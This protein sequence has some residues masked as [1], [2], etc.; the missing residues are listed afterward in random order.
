[1]KREVS[2]RVKDS[3]PTSSG[4]DVISSKDRLLGEVYNGYLID[5]ANWR[6]GIQFVFKGRREKWM[7]SKIGSGYRCMIPNCDKCKANNSPPSKEKLIEAL[8]HAIHWGWYL[9]PLVGLHGRSRFTVNGFMK[10]ENSDDTDIK[11]EGESRVYSDL[12]T[13]REAADRVLD[14]MIQAYEELTGTGDKQRRLL[15]AKEAAAVDANRQLR[16]TKE[17]D[18][19]EA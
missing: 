4:G 18:F 5:K 14:Y 8:A 1:M 2:A 7:S 13:A 19:N 17:V 15:Q 16:Q 11:N 3:S 9:F 6:L 10:C 12:D